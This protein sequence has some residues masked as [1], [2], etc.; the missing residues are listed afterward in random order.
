MATKIPARVKVISSICDI[1]E[2]GYTVGDEERFCEQNDATLTC[3]A[4]YVTVKYTACTEGQSVSTAIITNGNELTVRRQG[5]ISSVLTF[6]K[7][8]IYKT[9]YEIA[10]Y[11][12]DMAVITESFSANISENGGS[13]DIVYRMEIGGSARRTHMK[14]EV[15]V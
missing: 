7:D 9:L 2:R 11:K 5:A 1:D 15:T 13:A 10:P 14:I 12:F 3:D 4:G 6:G 8:M